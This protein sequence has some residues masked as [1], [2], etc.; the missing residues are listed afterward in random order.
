MKLYCTTTRQEE[1]KM[2][3]KVK[4]KYKIMQAKSGIS[5]ID[6]FKVSKE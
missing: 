2:E 1:I 6:E 3:T 5:F 4:Q